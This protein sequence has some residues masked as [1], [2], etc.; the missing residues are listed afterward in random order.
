M[1]NGNIVCEY[2]HNINVVT[3]LYS[4]YPV[5]LISKSNE[6]NR[7]INTIYMCNFGGGLVSNDIH[8]IQCNLMMNANLC[9][10]T[11]GTSKIYRSVNN[12]VSLQRI[13][14]NLHSH[15]FLIFV[16]DPTSCY[17]HSNYRSEQIFHITNSS[18]MICLDW[19]NSGRKDRDENWSADR[20]RSS[21]AIH[22]NEKII[23]NENLD[24]KSN[25]EG[26]MAGSFSTIS[27]KVGNVTLFG[28]LILFGSRTELI[29][30]RLNILRKR[31]TFEDFK[32]STDT[33]LM[34]KRFYI[35]VSSLNNDMTIVR[36][37]ADS[38]EDTYQFLNEI[39]NSKSITDQSII[40]AKIFEG[41]LHCGELG[42]SNSLSS[43]PAIKILNSFDDDKFT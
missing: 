3:T 34:S 13:H 29:R 36:F 28:S 15:S 10:K 22:C 1:I 38:I 39:L 21:I 11:T 40:E 18:S 35:S 33:E 19:Y 2:I 26:D 43:I 7:L 37:F 12:N 30:K 32:S 25:D 41:R 42:K 31:Q 16:P 23:Y 8:S 4:S 20:I 5:R 24:L 27:E 6:N 9:L 17:Q 14:F